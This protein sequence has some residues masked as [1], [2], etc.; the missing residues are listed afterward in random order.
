MATKEEVLRIDR[1]N[2]VKFA[3][4]EARKGW[5]DMA[6]KNSHDPYGRGI[7]AYARRWAKLMQVE[8][9]KGRKL[10]EIA[11]QSSYDADLDGITGFMFGCAV[12]ALS[13]FW[14]YGEQLRR[15]HNGE[16]GYSGD[17]VVNPA[18][19]NVKIDG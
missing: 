4:E 6:E 16:Y 12:G 5:E 14:I 7:V 13:E 8:I 19:I 9:S 18:V 17:G 15:W 2:E 3:S 11:Q 10:E 1:E